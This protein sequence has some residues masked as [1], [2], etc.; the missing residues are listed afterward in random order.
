MAHD[1]RLCPHGN[2]RNACTCAGVWPTREA[3]WT[4]NVVA[5]TTAPW[6]APVRPRVLTA[7]EIARAN[8]GSWRGVMP[9]AVV[10]PPA[11]AV[12]TLTAPR[13]RRPR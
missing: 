1:P 12:L 13:S 6:P 8:D 2:L 5:N 11:V 9:A 7:E 3:G 10:T 4:S